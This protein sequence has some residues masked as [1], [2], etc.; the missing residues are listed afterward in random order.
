MR[1]RG[2][3]SKLNSSQRCACYNHGKLSANLLEDEVQKNSYAG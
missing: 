2:R 3:E 1:Y